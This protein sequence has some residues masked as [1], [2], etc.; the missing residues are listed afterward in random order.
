MIGRYSLYKSGEIAA[1]I[2]EYRYV[3]DNFYDYEIILC[4]L[5]DYN[6]K[7]EL[8]QR[9]KLQALKKCCQTVKRN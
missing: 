9:T 7:H 3:K 5:V 6:G 1:Q 2:A 4:V 8:V